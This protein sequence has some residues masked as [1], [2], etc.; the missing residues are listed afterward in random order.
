MNIELLS[1]PNSIMQKVAVSDIIKLNDITFKYGLTLSD[2]DIIS[3]IKTKNELLN[4]YGRIEFG[5]AL[6]NKVITKFYDSPY[7]WQD[8]YITT[9]E[10]LLEIFYYFK[11]ESIE[12]LTDDELLSIMKYHFDSTCRGSIELLQSRELEAITYKALLE[13]ENAEQE[14]YIKDEE[15]EDYGIN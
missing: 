14:E 7:I 2:K 11:N 4:N 15:E 10:E 5:G 6:I 1:I 3:I 13:T 12:E 9:I 8:N